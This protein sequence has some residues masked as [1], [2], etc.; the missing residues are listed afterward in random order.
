MAIGKG[1]AIGKAARVFFLESFLLS[2]SH[3][4][5]SIPPTRDLLS[6]IITMVSSKSN[7]C[8]GGKFLLSI[9]LVF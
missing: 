8:I 5:I 9:N 2:L 3:T 6:V 7:S 1:A 4:W